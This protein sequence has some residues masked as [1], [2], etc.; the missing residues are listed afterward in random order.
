MQPYKGWRAIIFPRA[1]PGC[2]RE[3]LRNP[4]SGFSTLTTTQTFV[5]GGFHENPA[6]STERTPR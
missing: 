1:Y 3:N 6:T 2:D 4:E 5:P